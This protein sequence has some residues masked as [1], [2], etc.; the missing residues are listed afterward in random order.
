M[1]EL[2][3]IQLKCIAVQLMLSKSIELMASDMV[4]CKTCLFMA[5]ALAA[6]S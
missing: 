2:L 6:G 1:Y 4:E 3:D 5:H